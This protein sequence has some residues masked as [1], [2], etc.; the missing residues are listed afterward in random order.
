MLKKSYLMPMLFLAIIA[1]S[2]SPQTSSAECDAE[3]TTIGS[4]SGSFVYTA[5][6]YI[7]ASADAFSKNLYTSEQLRAMMSEMISLLDVVEE[8]LRTLPKLTTEDRQTIY[9]LIEI[10]NLLKKEADALAAY[11]A[12]KNQAD[13]DTYDLNRKEAW[14]KIQTTLGIQ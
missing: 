13:A 9:A 14:S 7:G 3:L 5:Y 10:L 11:S 4:I 6:G 2:L 1:L 12:S 8:S